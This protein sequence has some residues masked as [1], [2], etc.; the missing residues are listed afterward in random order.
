MRNLKWNRVDIS[1]RSGKGIEKELS[2]YD[3][4]CKD[5]YWLL[6]NHNWCW[7]QFAEQIGVIR[8]TPCNFLSMK[9]EIQNLQ[10]SRIGRELDFQLEIF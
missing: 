6:T 1:F 9:S 3:E 8:T 4:A 10:A 2:G 5:N 7:I